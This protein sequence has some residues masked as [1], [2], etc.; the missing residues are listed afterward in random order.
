MAL[1]VGSMKLGIPSRM[2]L[3]AGWK[4][5]VRDSGLVSWGGVIL[6]RP[7]GRI[8]SRLVYY[9]D[10]APYYLPF[11]AIVHRFTDIDE[12]QG[13]LLYGQKSVPSSFE[14]EADNTNNLLLVGP[15]EPTLGRHRV[16]IRTQRR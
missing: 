6:V 3:H 10:A 11:E 2:C 15:L 4:G 12:T 1:Q 5:A 13:L 14:A 7:G 9:H 8:R 16:I